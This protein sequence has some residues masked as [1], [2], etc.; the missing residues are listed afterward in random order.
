MFIRVIVL[1]H[2]KKDKIE[3][4][5]RRIELIILEIEESPA[6]YINSGHR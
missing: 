1:S 4:S 3:N 5:G 2:Q 6:D